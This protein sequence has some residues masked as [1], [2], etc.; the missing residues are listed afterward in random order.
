[1]EGV[2]LLI[3][4][5]APVTAPPRTVRSDVKEDLPHGHITLSLAAENTSL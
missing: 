5:T 2:S 1:M 3:L 4:L